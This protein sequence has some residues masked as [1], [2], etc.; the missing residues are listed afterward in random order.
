MTAGV[1]YIFCE[2]DQRLYIGSSVNVETRIAKH[3]SHLRAGNHRSKRMQAAWN[4]YGESAFEFVLLAEVRPV[5]GYTMR[6]VLEAHEGFW[7]QLY[8]SDHPRWGYNTNGLGKTWL[9]Q[10]FDWSHA[11]LHGMWDRY[12]S[13]SGEINWAQR[14]A[15]SYYV[16]LP[17]YRRS[18]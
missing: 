5:I 1:Y 2:P 3:R 6:A 13:E 10:V 14:R 17:P 9:A 15:Q 18:E 11:H 4:E 12:W 16:A 7:V 8:R